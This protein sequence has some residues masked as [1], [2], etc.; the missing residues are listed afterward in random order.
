VVGPW[1]TYWTRD[2]V[3]GTLGDILDMGWGGGALG[4]ILDRG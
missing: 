3:V 4:D 1:G 2:R